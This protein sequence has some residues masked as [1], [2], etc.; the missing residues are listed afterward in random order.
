MSWID[1]SLVEK[2][3]TD[4]TMEQIEK[5]LENNNYEVIRT[6]KQITAVKKSFW[7]SKASTIV[8]LDRGD[9]R[10]CEDTETSK[11]YAV[12]PNSGVL[13]EIIQEAEEEK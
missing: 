6:R 10:E 7:S 1:S 12:R 5:A 8:V 3:I 9:Y 4:A 2:C 13:A 11:G